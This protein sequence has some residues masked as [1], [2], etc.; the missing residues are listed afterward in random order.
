MYDHWVISGGN[1]S[2]ALEN[3]AKMRF[4]EIDKSQTDQKLCM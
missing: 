3:T 2:D 1:F 4:I